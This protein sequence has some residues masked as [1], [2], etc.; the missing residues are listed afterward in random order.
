MYRDE[1]K[2]AN[3]INRSEHTHFPI[4]TAR[5]AEKERKTERKKMP[6]NADIK[7]YMYWIHENTEMFRISRPFF[8]G[9]QKV[10]WI[11]Y[12]KSLVCFYVT[13]ALINGIFIH[14][15]LIKAAKHRLLFGI[16][17]LLFMHES[18]TFFNCLLLSVR[19]PTTAFHKIF[20]RNR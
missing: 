6:T 8:F 2:R 15:M 12:T 9:T 3:S 11:A 5:D 1:A 14:K 10:L 19:N 13:Q 17:M 20:Q 7:M 18:S 4:F 16:S